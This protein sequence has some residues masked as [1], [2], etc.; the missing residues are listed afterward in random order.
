MADVKDKIPHHIPQILINMEALPHMNGFDVQLLGYCDSVVTELCRLLNWDLKHDKIIG[1]S[2]LVPREDVI[3]EIVDENGEII[4]R[5]KQFIRPGSLPHRFLFEGGVDGMVYHSD[6][7][8]DEE[9]DESSE[10]DS[11]LEYDSQ[12][13][14]EEDQIELNSH[15]V[16]L[17]Q[18]DQ[19]ATPPSQVN[20]DDFG[21]E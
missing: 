9:E 16:V 11:R 5:K 3:E 19:D 20:K 21:T 12:V 17:D 4:Q 6:V 15:P 8:S 13:D 10:D 1:G 18:Q 14:E 7:S 2:S